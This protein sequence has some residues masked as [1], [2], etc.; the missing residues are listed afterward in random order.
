MIAIIPARG[1]S[2]GLPGKNTKNLLGKPL[3][4]YTIEA[5][6]KAK[7]ITE[8]I[9]STDSQEIAEIAV[10]Y[11]AKCP[12]LRPAYLATDEALSVD[13]Y[14]HL[15]SKL[16]ENRNTEIGEFIVL[17]PT[18]PL[19]SY[20]DIDNAIKM[21]RE[22]NADSVISYTKEKHPITW[23]KY[24][25]SQNEFIDIFN[26]DLKNRQDYRCSYYPNGAI[27]VFKTQIINKNIY[28]TDKSY[29]YL[30]SS[31]DSIDI[32]T[33]DDFNYAEFILSNK[34]VSKT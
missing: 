20:Q 16:C 15:I 10:K 22:K 27:Y 2:K 14:I 24:L 30:M 33:I 34:G 4:S 5:A 19:R 25:N 32:D 6:K 17:Q 7:S 11:G 13:N 28:Y 8:I 31:R 29:A 12:F 9:I 26:D 18:S 21:F 3:I 1:G 23:H